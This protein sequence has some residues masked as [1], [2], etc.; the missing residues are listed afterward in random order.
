MDTFVHTMQTYTAVERNYSKA[1]SIFSDLIK[2]NLQD[3]A[4]IIRV[5]L[6]AS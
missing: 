5:Y 2:F 6:H 1:R 3:K 4:D